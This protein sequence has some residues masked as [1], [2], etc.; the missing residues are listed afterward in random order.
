MR[1]SKVMFL[2]L[3]SLLLV[4]VCCPVGYSEDTVLSINDLPSSGESLLI[5][6]DTVLTVKE[7]ESAVIDGALQINGTE[8]T[9]T[10]FK[11]IN[12]GLLTI[13][14]TPI[15]CNHSNFTIQNTGTL[16]LETVHFTVI[17]YST[18][19]VYNEG[20][21]MMTAASVD[22]FGGYA[23]FTNTGALTIHNGYFKDQFDGTCITNNGLAT[24]SSTVFVANGA[25]GQFDISNNG[26]MKLRTCSFDVNYGA[27]INLN[28]VGAF[29]MN[30]SSMDV[31]GWS[32][33]Q[34]STLNINIGSGVSVWE[35]C[36][37]TTSGGKINFQNLGNTRLTDCRI[38]A[39]SDGSVNV[40]N[41]DILTFEDS[42]FGGTGSVDV[43]NFDSM[44]LI[45]TVYN[46]SNYLA[47]Y[48]A[49]DLD[50]ENWIVTVAIQ[51]AEAFISN[52]G[53][54]TFFPS[55]IEGVSSSV[56]NSIGPEGKEFVQSSGGT[57][58]VT[59]NGAFSG[60]SDT[61]DGFDSSLIYILAIAAVAIVFL[62][63]FFVVKKKNRF[64]QESTA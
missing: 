4:T 53:N 45:D 26:D 44:T 21:C 32:H 37:Q 2:V 60:Q 30:A 59:N 43:A 56:I 39:S 16:N 62:V 15:G 27:L 38:T 20:S 6:S 11:I 61:N 51:N 55:F 18:L 7:N 35:S 31:S 14:N 58:T 3:F 50:A 46:S 13:K 10:D 24:L 25:K 12:N 1:G 17:G 48:T 54:L 33:G 28:T 8:T 36:E 40:A 19:A 41:H 47:L 52:D 34:Q 29:S 42:S 5:D 23:N 9:T 63:V 57:I 49:G 64:S 22:V